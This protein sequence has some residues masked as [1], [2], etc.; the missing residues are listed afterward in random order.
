MTASDAVLGTVVREETG[1]IVAALTR[2][3]GRFDIAEEAVA[4]AIEEA[5]RDWRRGGVPP[6]PGAWLMTAARHNALDAVRRDA[7]LRDRL[8]L[9][10]R[11]PVP[12]VAG[13]DERLALIF[14]CCHPALSPEAQLALMLRAV[15]GMTTAQIARAMREPT[16]TVGQRISRAKRKIATS[17]IPLRVPVGADRAARLDLVLTAISVMYD[18]AHLRDGADAAT[19]R[20][21]AEDALWLAAVVAYESAAAEAYGLHALLLFH[22]ARDAARTAGGE[23]VPLPAQERRLWDDALIRRARDVLEQAARLRDPGRWQLHAAIAACHADA[24]EAAATD[25]PQILVLYDM[26]LTFDRSPIVRLNRVVALAEVAGAEAALRETEA[27]ADELREDRLWHAVRAA[28][29]R[30]IGDI[31]AADASDRAA[32][33]LADSEAERRL[34]RSRVAGPA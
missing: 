20:D 14:G 28:L 11:E 3:F 9:L 31:A 15:V 29:L 18:A 33:A 12:A 32:L 13:P 4:A 5:L 21:V 19:D 10:E 25:W 7:R 1:R 22:R 26:L 34:L 2:A 30:R 17:G 6:R 23:L 27:L 24:T 8:A 16:A